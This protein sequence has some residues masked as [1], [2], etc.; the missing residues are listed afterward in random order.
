MVV[1]LD[2]AGEFIYNGIHDIYSL[3]H[4]SNDGCSFSAF[5]SISV[6]IERLQ[7]IV[8]ILLALDSY[9]QDDDFEKSIITHSH[10]K[11]RNMMILRLH[12]NSL[13]AI[14]E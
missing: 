13:T 11:L 12:I 1:E 4:F 3:K 9:S 6:G 14:W 8:Y 10:T 2:V 5:Y 7:K